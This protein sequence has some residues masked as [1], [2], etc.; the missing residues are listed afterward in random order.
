[1]KKYIIKYKLFDLD[2]KKYFVESVCIAT[3]EN[4][5]KKVE[6]LQANL[7]SGLYA[8]HVYEVKEL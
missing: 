2:E 3:E 6:E 8:R 5:E 7:E 1:M 4:L